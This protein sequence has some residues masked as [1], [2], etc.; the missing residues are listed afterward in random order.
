MDALAVFE[1]G[2]IRI[3]ALCPFGPFWM[4]VRLWSPL[5]CSPGVQGHYGPWGWDLLAAPLL[6]QIFEN[7]GA[8]MGCSNPHPHCQVRLSHP[9]LP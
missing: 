2:T 4:D 3:P 9:D 7:K 1:V 6:P 8:M 5:G